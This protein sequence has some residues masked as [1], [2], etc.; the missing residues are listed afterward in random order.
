MSGYVVDASAAVEVVL[1]TPL[2]RK[3]AAILRGSQLIAPELIDAEVMST[4]RRGVIRK[5]ATETE[6]IEA[7]QRHIEWPINRLP[8]VPLTMLAWEYRQSVSAYDALYLAAARL[9]QFPLVTIDARL[10][11]APVRDVAVLSVL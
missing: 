9:H 4:L 8:H 1:R 6:A 7:L 3:I 10:S 2:G 11:R 5:T